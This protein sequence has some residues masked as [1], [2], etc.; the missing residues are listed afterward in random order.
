MGPRDLARREAHPQRRLVDQL[1]YTAFNVPIIHSE[2]SYNGSTL[3]PD[4]R[5]DGSTPSSSFTKESQWCSTRKRAHR[6]AKVELT[7]PC[8]AA[9]STGSLNARTGTDGR[10]RHDDFKRPSSIMVL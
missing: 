7:Q 10:C 4:P 2:L 8:D 1:P 5:D 3:G 6:A 9:L